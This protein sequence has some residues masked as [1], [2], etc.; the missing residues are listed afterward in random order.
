MDH[1]TFLINLRLVN[2]LT[3]ITGAD[4]VYAHAAILQTLALVNQ[5]HSQILHDA[6]IAKPLSLALISHQRGVTLRVSLMSPNAIAYANNIVQALSLTG[7]M[8]RLGRKRCSIE[9]VE[10]GGICGWS[11]FFQKPAKNIQ[12]HF[13]T[14]TGINKRQP[15]HRH[16]TWLYPDPTD[17]FAGLM[18]RWRA[19]GGP[20]LPAGILSFIES[21]GCVIARHNLRT[22]E[23][24]T[25]ERTQIGFVGSVVYQCRHS[26]KE[27]T[28]ALAA[29]A[30]FAGF[31]GVGYQTARGMGAV[32]VLINS[33]VE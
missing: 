11:D 16:L 5:K 9:S 30:R 20:D 17:I 21:G 23:F 18:R 25:K 15:G 4:G 19:L 27:A 29:L 31:A 33:E 28:T 7:S 8:I 14:P 22:V 10:I 3:P 6:K 13:I 24:R 26:N 1:M 2:S 32:Q 12:I